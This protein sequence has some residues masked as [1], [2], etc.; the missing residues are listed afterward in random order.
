MSNKV[1]I[2]IGVVRGYGWDQVDV[3]ARS[4]VNC[5]FAG[6]GVV[7]VYDGG[8][9][10]ESVVRNLRR[11]DIRV[12]RMPSRGNVYHVRFEDISTVLRKL[13]PELRYA[14]VTDVRD[15]YFQSDPSL[16]LESNLNK[17]LL[18][19]S[20]AVRYAD[21]E[22]NRENMRLSFPRQADR[23]MSK[24]VCNA[25]VLA[26]AAEAM[27]DICLA[28]SLVSES[29]PASQAD[30]AAYNLLLDM[31]PYRSTVQIAA[32]EDGFT[33]QG[34][35][36]GS[37][38][39]RPILLE[40]V[41]ILDVEGVKTAGGKL[42]PIVHQYDRVPDWQA[43]LQAKAYE[44]PRES[45]VRETDEPPG[46]VSRLAEVLPELE[47]AADGTPAPRVTVVCP[48]YHR[49][50]FLR[51]VV[52]SYL[53]QTF[54]GGLE[55]IILDD[56]PERSEFIDD[57][58]FQD[59]G[60]RYHHISDRRLTTGAKLNLMMQAARGE[61][62]MEF[63]DD[64]YYSPQYVER[65]IEFLGDADFVTLSRWFCYYPDRN[66]FGYWST[67]T[68]APVHFQLSPREPV[69]PVST[70]IWDR[71]SNEG[72]VWGFG[73]SFVWRKSVYPDV[74]IPDTPGGGID[75]DLEFS[76]NL[77]K[78]GFK[79]LAVPDD[80]GL[81]LHIVHPGSSVRIFPQYIMPEF[82]VRTFFPGY[83][84]LE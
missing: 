10:T 48:T 30:Q 14:I 55:M 52:G 75:S 38:T 76:R 24:T 63:D 70:H 34:G 1:D 12:V 4:L 64:D 67:D 78:A 13:L 7:I 36:L 42:Y 8:E 50:S 31:E 53:A 43:L 59:K 41:P 77:Q 84:A 29:S 5:G 66:T 72:N 19:V 58:E 73:F 81:V 51:R 20:E 40:P 45:P 71:G 49:S 61:I 18:A 23:L 33:C 65:M 27:A 62:I 37:A 57:P 79:T 60:I 2:V 68:K 22:W 83:R 15:V 80:E 6:V 82:T 26:G 54:D 39:L 17:P 16:W 11:L 35:T 25:G 69:E 3:W 56:S 46:P 44:V 74:E 9:M 32:S 21:E 28:V 47:P